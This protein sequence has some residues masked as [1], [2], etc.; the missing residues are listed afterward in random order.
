MAIEFQC[1]FCQSVLKVPDATAGKKA[2]CP[3]CQTVVQIPGEPVPP[4]GELAPTSPE[5][6]LPAEPSGSVPPDNPYLDTISN[7]Y[8]EP[9]SG[10]GGQ[11]STNPYVGSGQNP[12]AGS[13]ANPYAGQ[14]GRPSQPN[15]ANPYQ[16]A[17]STGAPV[18]NN[19]V[20]LRSRI[21]AAGIAVLVVVSLGGLGMLFN[22][23]GVV[24]ELF[25]GRMRGDEFG[26]LVMAILLFAGQAIGF[27]G[28]LAM[29]QQRGHSLAIAGSITTAL[30]GLCCCIP[31]VIGI[32]ALTVLLD[33]RA[34]QLMNG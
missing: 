13:P 33:P 34:R 24:L 9:A 27:L 25:D 6:N 31:T 2:R 28:A 16:P 18:R 17:T 7:P 21:R 3:S 14:T 23:V 1:K 11:S 4:V 19:D 20:E 10:E 8:G 12:Y 15:T 30:T 22:L 5:I 32:Y 26:E 29:I